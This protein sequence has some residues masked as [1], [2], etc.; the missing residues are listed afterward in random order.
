VTTTR[1]APEQDVEALMLEVQRYL[2]AVDAF[3]AEGREPRWSP[4]RPLEEVDAR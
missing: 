1:L 3:R 2:V 4:E